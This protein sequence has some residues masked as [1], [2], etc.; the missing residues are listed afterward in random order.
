MSAG[1]GSKEATLIAHSLRADGFDVSEQA[2]GFAW[3]KEVAPAIQAHPQSDTSSRQAGIREHV[4]RRLT[5]RS[6]S[7][8]RASPTA[9]PDHLARQARRRRP[10]LPGFGQQHGCPRHRLDTSPDRG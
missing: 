2:N 10:A 5:P 1:S 6:A 7:A 8:S 9:D 4:R 3:E